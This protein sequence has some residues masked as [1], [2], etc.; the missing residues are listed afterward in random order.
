M[1]SN[2]NGSISEFFKEQSAAKMESIFC[3]FCKES[4]FNVWTDS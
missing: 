3:A 1:E 2:A 4:I